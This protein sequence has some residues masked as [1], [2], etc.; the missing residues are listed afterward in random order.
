[1][2]ATVGWPSARLYSDENP[3]SRDRRVARLA[4]RLLNNSRGEGAGTGRSC[5]RSSVRRC[6]SSAREVASGFVVAVAGDGGWVLVKAARVPSG[7]GPGP[8]GAGEP[9]SEQT[10][11]VE[12][13]DAVVQPQVVESRPSE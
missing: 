2:I 10:A 6:E 4:R 5:R 1:M 8:A 11:Q 12:L 9:E 13:G 7:G 3:H